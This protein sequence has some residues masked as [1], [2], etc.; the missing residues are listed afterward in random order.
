[1]GCLSARLRESC[2]LMTPLTPEQKRD[3]ELLSTALKLIRKHRGLTAAEVAQALNMFIRTYENFENGRTRLNQDYVYR[4][5]RVTDSDPYGVFLSIMLG[6][7]Q[8][9][10]DCADNKLAS[11]LLLALRENYAR[12]PETL[13]AVQMR[14]A[15]AIF[16]QMFDRL[17][18]ETAR[19]EAS[20]SAWLEE[21]LAALAEKR[22][23]PGQ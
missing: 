19:R 23:K 2:V 17:S 21:G 10:L 14:D 6:N 7:P 9:A 20:A 4:F 22:P 12:S 13:P 1:M 11:V 8:F 3:G 16:R 15:M 18:D 5:C